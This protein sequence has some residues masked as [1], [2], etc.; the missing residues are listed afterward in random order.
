MD[1]IPPHLPPSKS[2]LTF[3]LAHTVKEQHNKP[4]GKTTGE[5]PTLLK[6]MVHYFPQEKMRRKNDSKSGWM[7]SGLFLIFFIPQT[8]Q[9]GPAPS[10]E[11]LTRGSFPE[12]VTESLNTM[13]RILKAFSILE[14]SAGK[15]L[16]DLK[17]A[18]VGVN[19]RTAQKLY[20]YARELAKTTLEKSLSLKPQEILTS[21]TMI[22]E[23][24][25]FNTVLEQITR[26][27][28]ESYESFQRLNKEGQ[29][30]ETAPSTPSQ[31]GEPTR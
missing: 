20:E 23:W 18:V 22:P 14:E 15:T 12:V 16:P 26:L 24:R 21:P 31:K 13:E 28:Q 30:V 8:L 5:N 1:I 29:K 6:G 7:L 19:Y 25:M 27:Y 9:A 2:I 10:L 3:F 4:E 11:P 17:D